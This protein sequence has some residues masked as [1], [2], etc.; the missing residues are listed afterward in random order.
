MAAIER[1][2]QVPRAHAFARLVGGGLTALSLLAVAPHRA[3]AV[4]LSLW[5]N[6]TT[7]GQATV[8]QKQ[9]NTCAAQQPGVTIKFET[10]PFDSMYTRLITAMRRGDPPNLMNTLE[11]AVAFMQAKG[12]LVP[13]TDTVQALGRDDFITSYLQA[14]SKDGDV[15]GLPDWALHQ[16]VWYR[17]DLF[18]QAGLAV[19][20]SWDQLLVAAKA[21]TKPAEG[22][23]PAQYG[24]AVPMGRALVAPQTFFQFFYAA[25]G[26][27][28]DPKTGDYAFGDE[29]AL[30]VKTLTFMLELYKAASPPASVEWSWTEYRTA[31][32]KGLVAMTNEWG[33]V[34]QMAVEQNPQILDQMG[35]F[36]FPSPVVGQP[37]AASLSG[38]YY[39]LVGKSTPEK[40]AASK[41]LLK[42]LYNPS[43]VGERAASRP[44]FAIP[45][46]RSGY[47]S[48]EYA[49]NPML[50]RFKPELDIIF[51]QV[52]QHWYRYGMEG[53]LNP[54]AG[55]IEATTFIGDAIQ[56]AALG[57]ITPDAA[58]TQMDEQL[59]FQAEI[60]AH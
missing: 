45:A 4:E 49:D 20:Q 59:R 10:V 32:V 31:F 40:V 17:K 30:A 2:I 38:G 5:T 27:I 11:G 24:F 52:M 21:L 34:V 28:M 9:A 51:N 14:V 29:K 7:A 39:Y 53:G 36:P 33:A 48:K 42:C 56:N 25:G 50:K 60:L 16:E 44:I 8:I 1:P 47:A 19:P 57:K 43:M 41:T 23:K 55:Q 37:P 18:A 13:V 12:G 26:T 15:W 54:L 58:V 35:V 6:L 22:G 46:T 3:A